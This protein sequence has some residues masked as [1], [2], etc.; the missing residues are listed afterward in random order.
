MKEKYNIIFIELTDNAT[1]IYKEYN[2]AH[3]FKQLRAYNKNITRG[4]RYESIAAANSTD[5]LKNDYKYY[6]HEFINVNDKNAINA[7]INELNNI[8]FFIDMKDFQT[9]DDKEME[10]AL[11]KSVEILKTLKA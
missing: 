5:V 3:T 4:A 6:K 11:Y 9:Y 1:V 7:R 10:K 8:R 2:R